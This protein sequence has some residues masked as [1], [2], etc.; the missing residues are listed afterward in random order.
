MR[1]KSDLESASLGIT[2]STPQQKAA[3]SSL[4]QWFAHNERMWFH[5]ILVLLCIIMIFPIFFTLLASLR[6][7]GFGLSRDI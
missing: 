7:T 3:T 2:A 1:D 4:S 5:V 6:P